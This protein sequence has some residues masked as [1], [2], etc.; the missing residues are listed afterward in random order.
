MS[1]YWISPQGE[2]IVIKGTS[3]STHIDS[4]INNPETFGLTK[5][6]IQDVYDMY[7]EK[8][9]TEGKARE[10]IIRD[11]VDKGWIRVR[12]Y[13]QQW[14]ININ[15]ITKKIKD[16]IFDFAA[17]ITSDEGLFGEKEKDL[18]MPVKVLSF[19]NDQMDSYTFKD[20]LSGAMYESLEKFD[21]DNILT[22]VVLNKN[23]MKNWVDFL[24]G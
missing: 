3:G 23:K 20:L 9:G 24:K 6:K 22:E 14:S 18:Y 5:S 15:R 10:Q 11:L 12:K 16:Y 8:L 13:R 7:G 17:K 2:I 1:A 4:V 21:D 19:H